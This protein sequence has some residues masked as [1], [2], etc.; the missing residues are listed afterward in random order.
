MTIELRI[1]VNKGK[2]TEA[3][4]WLSKAQELIVEY[5]EHEDMLKKLEAQHPTPSGGYDYD[6]LTVRHD[7]DWRWAQQRQSEIQ[8]EVGRLFIET[9]TGIQR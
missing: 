7:L 2:E 3:A 1:P 4:V 6:F 9:M 8:Q 5:K